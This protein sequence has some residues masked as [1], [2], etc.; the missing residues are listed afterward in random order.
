MRY[1]GFSKWIEIIIICLALVSC[2]LSELTNETPASLIP[3][4]I[5]NP[6]Q[7]PDLFPDPVLFRCT[8]LLLVG[9]QIYK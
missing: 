9:R 5:P 6:T 2:N 1:T 3:T 8:D 4:E 7:T